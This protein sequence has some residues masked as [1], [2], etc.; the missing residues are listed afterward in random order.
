M[1]DLI[2]REAAI[3][4]ALRWYV[5]PDGGVFNAIKANIRSNLEQVPVVDAVPVVH[6]RWIYESEGM[7]DYSH[8]SECGC[9][10]DGGRISDLSVRYKFCPNCGA[11][12]NERRDSE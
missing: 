6:A 11:K 4:A 8:C 7:G 12:M 1:D 9:R 5:N 10:V 2:S 3:R